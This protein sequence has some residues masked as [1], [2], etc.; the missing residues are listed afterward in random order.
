MKT[1]E[2]VGKLGSGDMRIQV[3]H[4]HIHS[5]VVMGSF[6]SSF[7]YTAPGKPEHS[8][9]IPAKD[10]AVSGHRASGNVTVFG[11]VIMDH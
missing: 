4:T 11:E 8:V 2:S 10:H 7:T 1:G 3:R 6:A 5:S 9:S